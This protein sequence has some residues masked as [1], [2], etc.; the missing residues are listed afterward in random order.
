VGSDLARGTLKIFHLVLPPLRA[1]PEDILFLADH[2]LEECAGASAL[3]GVDARKALVIH[4]WP[5]NVRELRHAIHR[6]ATFCDGGLVRV[7]HL[8]PEA[9]SLPERLRHGARDSPAPVETELEQEDVRIIAALG[10]ANGRIGQAARSLGMS[11]ST[12]W[13]RMRANRIQPHMRGTSLAS[14]A[15]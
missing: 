6:A 5:G 14:R 11:R 15:T 1:R 10:R 3:L 8:P 2:F 9:L 13:R 7:E 4:T 12:M